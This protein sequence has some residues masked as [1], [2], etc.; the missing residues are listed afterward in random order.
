MRGEVMVWSFNDYLGAR[1]F[2]DRGSESE[3]KW[4]TQFP[5]AGAA[6]YILYPPLLYPL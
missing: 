6:I 1:L 2:K 5:A 4:Y 3:R